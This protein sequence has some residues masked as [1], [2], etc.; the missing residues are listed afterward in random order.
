M[1]RR[2]AGALPP[3]PVHRCAAL[4]PALSENL[5]ALLLFYGTVDWRLS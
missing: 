1:T 3:L 4:R 2:S 5:T